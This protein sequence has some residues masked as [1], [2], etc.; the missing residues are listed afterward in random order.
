MDKYR[1]QN[2]ISPSDFRDSTIPFGDNTELDILYFS[3]GR[4]KDDSAMAGPAVLDPVLLPFWKMR[5]SSA[6]VVLRTLLCSLFYRTATARL[7]S[8]YL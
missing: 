3:N 7:S 1:V 6:F 4:S 5:M 8:V 2:L